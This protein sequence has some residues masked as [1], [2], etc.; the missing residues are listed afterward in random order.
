VEV[1]VD[2]TVLIDLWR[3]NKRP[4]RLGDL[5]EKTRGLSLIVP[6]IVEA[7]FSRGALHMGLKREQIE[8]FY[9]DFMRAELSAAAL[10]Q[11]AE[12]WG[13][14]AQ[15]GK[16]TDYPDLWVA[17]SALERDCGLV[18]RNAKHFRNIPELE[19]IGY[20]LLEH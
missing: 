14:L 19:V 4:E 17:V 1:I 10:W 18:T 8:S 9:M 5:K 16:I 15:A 6:W 3:C 12:L 7:E 20:R 2:T 11:Y 13:K